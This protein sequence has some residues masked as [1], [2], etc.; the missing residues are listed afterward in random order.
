MAQWID[1]SMPPTASNARRRKN[2][3][4]WTMKSP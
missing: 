1:A 3:A 2:A 4:G